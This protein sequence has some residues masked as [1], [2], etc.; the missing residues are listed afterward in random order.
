MIPK[1][2]YRFERFNPADDEAYV[3]DLAKD[4]VIDAELLTN[5]CGM[6]FIE[7]TDFCL[8]CK[9]HAS[10]EVQ[11]KTGR[12]QYDNYIFVDVEFDPVD[13]KIINI[14]ASYV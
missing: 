9:E 7:N 2:P 14:G 1:N 4:A 13:R 6:P 10:A 11:V 12:D 3:E 8:D 5:C